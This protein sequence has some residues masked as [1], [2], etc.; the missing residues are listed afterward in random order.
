LIENKQTGSAMSGNQLTLVKSGELDHYD[1]HR[2]LETVAIAEAAEKHYARAKDA[3]KLF[4]AIEAKLIEQ[5][6]FVRW[7]NAQEKAKGGQPYQRKSTRNGP[8]TGSPPVAGRDGMPDR[9]VI[10]RWREATKDGR[11]E[12]TLE[13]AQEQCRRICERQEGGIVTGVAMDSY[14]ER[15]MDLYETPPGATRALLDVESFTGTIWEPANGRGAISNVLRSAGYRVAATDLVEYGLSDALG[16]VDFLKQTSAPEGV[17]TILTNP[18]FMHADDFVRH[19]LKLVPHVVMLLRLLFLESE[20]RSDILENGQLK[21]VYVF[22]GRIEMHR[23]GWTGPRESNPMA[24]AWFMWNRNHQGPA[25][26]H[27]ISSIDDQA[28]PLDERSSGWRESE[29]PVA[30]ED[31]SSPP[32]LRRM[33]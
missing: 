8:V 20:G 27:R 4:E 29:S 10:K 12:R 9:M 6:K 13:Q 25:T 26:L 24:F 33:E 18:P 31:L 16:G 22:R 21:R 15:G 3:T 7:W 28:P 1:P 17:Q 5:R 2:G 14:A 19:A 32:F 30:A 23:D 11:F